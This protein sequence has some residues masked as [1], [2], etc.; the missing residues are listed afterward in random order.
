MRTDTFQF[1]FSSS[2]AASPITTVFRLVGFGGAVHLVNAVLL[3]AVLS[4]LNSCFFASSRMLVSLAQSGQ[5]PSIFAWSTKRGV[6]V[7][8]LLVT[9]AISFLSFLT[10]ALGNG[11]AFT[12]LLNVSVHLPIDIGHQVTLLVCSS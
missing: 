9:L 12:W 6:P 11:K 4:A 8:A 10:S 1:D 2:V 5:A 7:P 3:T